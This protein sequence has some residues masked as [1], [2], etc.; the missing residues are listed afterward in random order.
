LLYLIIYTFSPI[1]GR[2]KVEI[3]MD[4]SNL[5]KFIFKRFAKLTSARYENYSRNV[6][7]TPER[8][9]FLKHIF[10][11]F[12]YLNIY[13]LYIATVDAQE[14]YLEIIAETTLSESL[15]DSLEIKT[16]F[17]DFRSLQ[18]EADSL[19]YRFQH[20]GYI[21][22]TLEF[23]Q[24][25][26]D[27]TYT[28]NY[29]LG[30]KY[31]HLKV[32]YNT[33]LF[34]KRE[35]LQIV[36]EIEDDHFTLPFSAVE[37]SLTQ[38]NELKTSDGNAFARIRLSEFRREGS[39]V[40]AANLLLDEGPSRQIDSIAV[41][42]YEK[43]PKSFLKH[44]AGI[45][46]KK[47]FDRNKLNKQN[48]ILN[49]LGFVNT[50]KA[51]EVLFRKE[52]TTVFFYLEKRNHNLFDGIL[53]FATDEETNRLQFNGYL[54]LELNNNLNF[55]EQLLINYKADGNEQQNFRARAKLPYLFGSPVGA[56]LELKIF[57][58]DSTFVTTDQ[59]ARISYQIA[60]PSSAYVG[61]KA[62]ESS[63]LLDEALA[64]SAVEDY[65]AKFF[66]TG[67]QFVKTQNDPLFPAKTN[68]ALD[69]EFGT[70]EFSSNNEDQTR[71]S[72]WAATIFEL[73]YNNSVFLQ[74]NTSLILSDTYLTN[75]L[76]R[77]GGINSIRGFNENSIDATL[78]AVINTEYR[79]RFGPGF[80]LHSIIDIGYFENEINQ[81]EQQLYSFGI[82][83]GLLTKAG[84][85]KFSFANGI[86]ENQNF[87]FSNTK[88]HLSL[89]SRF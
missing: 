83:L 52:K 36:S 26:N 38:L 25:K 2:A 70:R 77:F 69:A 59:I 23:L 53:G 87:N 84:L 21:A 34:R 33:N 75:E 72:L 67:L 8:R 86:L 9:P 71:L 3:K 19:Q 81:L 42:G 39:D 68:I 57:K 63:N 56:E 89:T 22:A 7:F 54:N 58:R 64:G 43:F 30:K 10:Y 45:K 76:F 41:K 13:T 40:I 85:L 47:P 15:K 80:Y 18:K 66:I 50:L 11:I 29:L 49:G 65:K 62:S 27:S 32:Y 55:G 46:K 88:I 79:Y 4:Y 61:Y 24:K 14:L 20:L 5:R 12:L 1:K 51:P 28:A 60:P 78:F 16:D 74:N 37:K 35:L 17:E 31:R 73:N 82:G 44:Y 48:D 6:S